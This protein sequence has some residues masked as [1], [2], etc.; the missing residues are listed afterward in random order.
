MASR[1][2]PVDALRKKRPRAEKQD[3]L[4]FIRSLPCCLCVSTS[5]I[6]AAHIRMASAKYAKQEAGIGQKPDDSWTVPLC[7]RH[8]RSQHEGNERAFWLMHEKDPFILALILWKHSGD[9]D[10][11]VTALKNAR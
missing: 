9:Y 4:T 10:A 7:A 1:L 6:E 8:H 2:K 11:A 5:T 3:H